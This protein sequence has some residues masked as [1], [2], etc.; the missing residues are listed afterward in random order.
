MVLMKQ[1]GKHMNIKTCVLHKCGL[2]FPLPVTRDQRCK[3]RR[4][5]QGRASTGKDKNREKQ[6]PSWEKK[7]TI[8]GRDQ[9][10]ENK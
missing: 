1:T 7:D 2:F 10:R 4:S 6:N 5:P 9:K 8:I 3:W